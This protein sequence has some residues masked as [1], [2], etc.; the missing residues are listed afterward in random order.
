[1]ATY[2]ATQAADQARRSDVPGRR[3]RVVED[4]DVGVGAD[5]ELVPHRIEREA[6]Q[7]TEAAGPHWDLRVCASDDPR[8]RDLRTGRWIAVLRAANTAVDLVG[9]EDLARPGPARTAAAT[10]TGGNAGDEHDG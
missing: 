10:T 3:S 1:M 9:G 6:G 4:E 7:T 8:Y 2:S 5:V